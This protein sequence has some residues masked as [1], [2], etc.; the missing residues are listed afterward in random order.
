MGGLTMGEER[1]YNSML[2]ELKKFNENLKE[3]SNTLQSINKTLQNIDDKG[4]MLQNGDHAL[5]VEV[6]NR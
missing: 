5:A 4:L 3:I 1:L 2:Q 6:K